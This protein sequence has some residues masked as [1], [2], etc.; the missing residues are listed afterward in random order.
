MTQV[1]GGQR[2]GPGPTAVGLR[3]PQPT[4]QIATGEVGKDGI[5]NSKRKNGHAAKTTAAG[6]GVTGVTNQDG[7]DGRQMVRTVFLCM[8][9]GG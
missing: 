5:I 6:T 2:H 7:D 8:R 9:H 3:H 4:G 1:L